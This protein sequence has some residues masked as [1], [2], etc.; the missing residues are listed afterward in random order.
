MCARRFLGCVFFLIL[1]AVAGAFAIFQFG[2]RILAQM[3]TPTG[4]YQPPADPGPD[5]AKADAWL[6]RPG[7]GPSLADWRPSLADGSPPPP[8][9]LAPTNAATFYIH[10]TTYLANDRWNA[11]A[12]MSGEPEGR[13]KLFVQSQASAFAG[14]TQL[15]APRYRQAAFGAF[16][17][18]S[19]DATKALDLAYSDVLRAFDAFA[20]ANPGKPLILAGHSQGSLHLLRLLRDRRDALKGRLVAAYV[21]GWPVDAKADLPELGLAAC[22]SAN[23]TPCLLSWQSFGD[24][25]NPELVER[26]WVGKAGFNGT[27]R[28]KANMI[29]TNPLTGSPAPAPASANLGTLVPNGDLTSATLELGL[30]GAHCKD[31]FLIVDGKPP[32]LGNYVMPGNNYHAYDYALWWGSIRADAE[33]RLKAFQSR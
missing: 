1:I 9:S 24:P 21:G 13:A 30:I 7:N 29:C 25:A 16:L 17:L 20:A 33:R 3:A 2:D 23:Q 5:Y 14:F 18:T 26:A 12:T 22:S 31:G 10:P 32:E 11:P 4:H 28:A 15:W 8:M 6:A 27:K 19:E